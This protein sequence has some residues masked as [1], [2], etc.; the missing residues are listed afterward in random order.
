MKN[1]RAKN[2]IYYPKIFD[3]RPAQSNTAKNADAV[4]IDLFYVTRPLPLYC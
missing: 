3:P 2:G 4:E 1:A